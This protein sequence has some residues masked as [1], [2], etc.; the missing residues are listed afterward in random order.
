MNPWLDTAAAAV[1]LVASG[2]AGAAAVAGV[3]AV[4]GGRGANAVAVTL[5]LAAGAVL[6]VVLTGCTTTVLPEALALLV[7]TTVPATGADTANL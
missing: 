3:L 5:V 2:V 4:A 7:L 6:G 1:V